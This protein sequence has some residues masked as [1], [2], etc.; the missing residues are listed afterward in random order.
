MSFTAVTSANAALPNFNALAGA[1]SST[2]TA[3]TDGGVQAGGDTLT[4]TKGGTPVNVALAA[5]DQLT[6]IVVK[7]NATS[8]VGVIASIVSGKLQLKSTGTG[9]SAVVQRYEQRH[10]GRRRSHFAE[11]QAA[12]DAIFSVN[13]SSMTSARTTTSPPAIPGSRSTS[14]G[15]TQHDAHG[16]AG[17][18]RNDAAGRVADAIKA[19]IT[20]FVDAYNASLDFVH[21]KTQGESQGRQPQEPRRVPRRARS[22]RDVGVLG[23]RVRPALRSSVTEV[24]GSLR[25]ANML[26][27]HRHQHL[28]HDRQRQC[29]AAS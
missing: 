13:G 5:G 19:K 14:A 28:L 21:Q 25:G 12:Q 22:S 8:G 1:A 18:A 11:T 9:A 17:H 3:A 10:D 7:I 24:A 15:T 6:D 29:T 23:L 16:C 26:C 20:A 27:E 4:I 2:T